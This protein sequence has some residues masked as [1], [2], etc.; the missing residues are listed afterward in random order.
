ME[1]EQRV[2]FITVIGDGKHM[3]DKY[4]TLADERREKEKEKYNEQP[5]IKSYCR[6]TS[7]DSR[8]D[9]MFYVLDTNKLDNF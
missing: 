9:I 1:K 8:F 7:V 6:A 2:D 5:L 4:D 3:E